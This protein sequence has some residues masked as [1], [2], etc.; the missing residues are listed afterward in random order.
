MAT[1]CSHSAK[2]GAGEILCETTIFDDSK[3]G[4]DKTGVFG[5]MLRQ[6][7]SFISNGNWA[8]IELTMTGVTF[9]DLEIPLHSLTGRAQ[10]CDHVL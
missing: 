6:A 3:R 9:L 5:M 2:A 4:K 8:R 7:W 1:T 10:G